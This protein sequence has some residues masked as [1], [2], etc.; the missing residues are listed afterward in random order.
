MTTTSSECTVVMATYNGAKYLAERLASLEQQAAP[1]ARL[2]IS[3]DGSSD[4]TKE[5]SAAFAKKAAFDVMLVDGPQQGYAENFWSA[6]RLADTRYLAWADQDDVWHPQK[7]RNA[8]Q[9]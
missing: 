9:R 4:D 8:W 7:S 3:D 1:P 6:A 2:I 5:I